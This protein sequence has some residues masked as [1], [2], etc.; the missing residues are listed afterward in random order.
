L[1]SFVYLSEPSLEP[2]LQPMIS[3]ILHAWT[4]GLRHPSDLILNAKG[5]RSTT[6]LF[7]ILSAEREAD[8]LSNYNIYQMLITVAQSRKAVISVCDTIAMPVQSSNISP[9]LFISISLPMSITKSLPICVPSLRCAASGAMLGRAVIW[10]RIP[11]SPNMTY[12]TRCGPHKNEW[13]GLCEGSIWMGGGRVSHEE[14]SNMIDRSRAIEIA[15]IRVL[16]LRSTWNVLPV[17]YWL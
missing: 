9:F 3:H 11:S 12:P 13:K 16:A 2:V 6:L 17:V 8:L 4:G 5:D 10:I 1:F 14:S 7:R 15:M